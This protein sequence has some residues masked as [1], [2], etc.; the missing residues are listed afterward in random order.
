MLKV[1]LT[2][3]IGSGKSTV[4]KIL[5]NEGFSVYNSDVRA[6]WL[7]NNDDNLKSNIDLFNQFL[8]TY[9]QY[10]IKYL[11]SLQNDLKNLYCT[12]NQEINF[13]NITL[14]QFEHIEKIENPEDKDISNNNLSTRQTIKSIK[15]H[16]TKYKT[17]YTLFK[18]YTKF[19]IKINIFMVS[20]TIVYIYLY[21]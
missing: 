18:Y 10:H 20:L 7:M 16:N 3:G 1:G 4:S 6:K 14:E 15:H 12:I 5:I 19:F 21:I 8:L 2:G 9:T 11:S 13:D 17:R